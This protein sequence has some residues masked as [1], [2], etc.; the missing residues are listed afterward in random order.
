MGR[1]GAGEN[2]VPDR[3]SLLHARSQPL[4]QRGSLPKRGIGEG[5]NMIE[6]VQIESVSVPV[7]DQE[8]AKE[9]YVDTLGFDL[10]VDYTWREGMLWSEV[11]PRNSA[12]SLMLVTWSA[13]ML[14]SMYRV[15]VLATDDIQ[16]IHEELV[17]KGID[18]ELPLTETPRGTQA[19]FR[20]PD[21]NAL[22]LWEHAGAQAEAA[23]S[24]EPGLRYQPF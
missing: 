24:E 19:M 20:D 8:Q 2:V 16:A 4:I 15:I 6:N 13:C 14:P 22:L 21:G 11:A 7:S 9:F 5:E 18:F 12:I 17:A 1:S 3:W 10:L 23:A